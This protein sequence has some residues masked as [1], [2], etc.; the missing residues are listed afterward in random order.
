MILNCNLR[1]K[2]QK[3]KIRKNSKKKD[4]FEFPKSIF[5]H[6]PLESL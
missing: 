5:T 1:N 3:I 2:I 6:I 4:S